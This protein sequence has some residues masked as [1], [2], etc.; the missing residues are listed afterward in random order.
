[1]RSELLA[2]IARVRDQLN[3]VERQ[4]REF[5][6]NKDHG[7]LLANLRETANDLEAAVYRALSEGNFEVKR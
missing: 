7:R 6:G 4:L 5:G 1:M 2:Q 3:D